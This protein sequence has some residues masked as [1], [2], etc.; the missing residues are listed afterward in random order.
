MAPLLHKS[1]KV[2]HQIVQCTNLHIMYNYME[3]KYM[4]HVLTHLAGPLINSIF[5]SLLK[6]Y[7]NFLRGK[8]EWL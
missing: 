4:G 7:G 1:P 6:R 5:S 8:S 3:Q 2:E